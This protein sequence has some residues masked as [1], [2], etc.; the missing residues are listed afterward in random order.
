MGVQL[1]CFPAGGPTL[2]QDGTLEHQARAELNAAT[3]TIANAQ[4]PT[5]GTTGGPLL[6]GA[7]L[8]GKQIAQLSGTDNTGIQF[9]R[10]YVDGHQVAQAAQACDF[11]YMAPCP[12]ASAHPVSLDTS[13][14]SDGPHQLQLALADPSGNETR[15]PVRPL[16]TDNTAPA[17]PVALAAARRYVNSPDAVTWQNPDQ[18]A[19]A[20]LT[21]VHWQVC[22]STAVCSAIQSQTAPLTQLTFDPRTLSPFAVAP[23]DHYTISVWLEDAAGN[24]DAGMPAR[25]PIIFSSAP[26]P[27]VSDLTLTPPRSNG[28]RTIATWQPFAGSL[29]A[30]IAG[31]EW[32]LC[33]EAK[34]VDATTGP[35]LTLRMPSPGRWTLS[36]RERDAAGNLSIARTAE[37]DYVPGGDGSTPAGRR[38]RLRLR[39]LRVRV[40]GQTVTV[41]GRVAGRGTPPRRLR[42]RLAAGG[43]MG[44]RESLALSVPVRG[45]HFSVRVELHAGERLISASVAG[46]GVPSRTCRAAGRGVRC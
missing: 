8:A 44:V 18:G 7:W 45:R 41:S 6:S 37:F 23:D 29:P 14:L 16:L 34:C 43:L 39:Q 27:P 20:P 13:G 4:A 15:G 42:V 17:P 12:Q 1:V 32:S 46:T 38:A 25:I 2:C 21:V 5:F 30:P 19:G 36:V 33:Q 3:L 9:A 26:P 28:P 40:H 11:T 24:S 10:V 35:P 31:F 22:N